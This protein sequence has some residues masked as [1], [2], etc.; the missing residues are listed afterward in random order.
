MLGSPEY[1]HTGQ[2][3]ITWRKLLLWMCGSPEYQHTEQREI[4][5]QLLLY[6][7]RGSPE[8]QHTEQR[9]ITWLSVLLWMRGSPECQHTEQRGITWRMVLLWMRGSPEY[10]HTKQREITW[11]LLLFGMRGSP[12]C[13][14]SSRHKDWRQLLRPLPSESANHQTYSGVVKFNARPTELRGA[15]RNDCLIFRDLE[16]N[17]IVTPRKCEKYCG[18]PFASMQCLWASKEQSDNRTSICFGICTIRIL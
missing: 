4:T 10:Q 2:R 6:G 17:S 18:N 14:Y 16:R 9:E 1:Q 12:E 5:C 7:M 3:G 13:L 11:Q 15:V 8:Y